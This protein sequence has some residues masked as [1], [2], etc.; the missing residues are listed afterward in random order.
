M[1]HCHTPL[2]KWEF[3]IVEDC[4]YKIGETLLAVS[5]FEL[6][7][8]IGAYISM[9]SSTERTSHKECST[10]KIQTYFYSALTDTL[11]GTLS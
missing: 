10:L 5:T 9:D 3:D 11:S 4:T 6:I 7:I 2:L 8:P 1:V